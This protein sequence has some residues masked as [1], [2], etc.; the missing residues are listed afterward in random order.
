M[1]ED[2]LIVQFSKM[3][4]NLKKFQKSGGTYTK[5]QKR[6]IEDFFNTFTQHAKNY[7]IHFNEYNLDNSYTDKQL[8]DKTKPI[9]AQLA[10]EEAKREKEKPKPKK[11]SEDPKE[12]K[13]YEEE[14]EEYERALEEEAE[15]EAQKR[16]ELEAERA[17]QSRLL[18]HDFSG[19]TDDE[20]KKINPLQIKPKNKEL[21]Y[22]SGDF[23][24]RSFQTNQ[25]LLGKSLNEEE[26]Y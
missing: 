14:M 18:K 12:R 22:M 15:R 10:M 24:I 26:D 17:K 7:G 8:A 9:T 4:N 13:S 1:A 5:E 21:D 6:V 23:D 25:L 20:L 3:T 2:Q 19:L 11:D 16:E